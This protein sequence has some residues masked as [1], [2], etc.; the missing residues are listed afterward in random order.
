[1]TGEE[2]RFFNEKTLI[3]CYRVSIS[4]IEKKDHYSFK[5]KKRDLLS[6]HANKSKQTM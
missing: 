5:T 4:K 3:H 2:K 1:M 6:T